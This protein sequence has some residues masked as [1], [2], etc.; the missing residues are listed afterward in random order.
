MRF[1][2]VEHRQ[3]VSLTG[4]RTGGCDQRERFLEGEQLALSTGSG[5]GRVPHGEIG[6]VA[7]EIWHLSVSRDE[8]QTAGAFANDGHTPSRCRPQRPRYHGQPVTPV[9]CVPS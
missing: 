4:D 8:K 9:H 6:T 5:V 7:G 1:A 2:P 3:V